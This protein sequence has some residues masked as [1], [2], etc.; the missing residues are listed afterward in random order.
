MDLPRPLDGVRVLDFTWVRAGPWSTRWLAAL[1]AEVLKVQWPY[2]LGPGQRIRPGELPRDPNA[3]ANSD[4]NNTNKLGITLNVRSEKGLSITKQLIAKSDVVIENFSATV[5]KRW[6]LAYEDMTAVNPKI[7][8]M[9]MAG[10]GHT[11]PYL[12]YTTFG[13]AAAAVAGLSL[14][15]GLPGKPPAGWGYSYLDDTGGMYG[16]MFVI[17]ALE[18]RNR[19]GEGQ[20]VDMGQMIMG[21]TLTGP[22]FLDYTVNGR[23]TDREGYPAGNRAIWPGTPPISGFRGRAAVPHNSYRTKPGDYNDWCVLGCFTDAEWEG[24]VKV[25][26]T[27]EWAVNAKYSTLL[28]RIRNQEELDQ[29][30]EEWT[31]TLDKYEIAQLCQAAGVPAAP[32]QSSEDRVDRDPQMKARGHFSS[33]L[34]HPVLGPKRHQSAPFTMSDAYVGV[35]RASPMLGQDTVE[36][37][38]RVL[39]MTKEEVK[40]G[41]KDG[42]FWPEDLGYYPQMEEAMNELS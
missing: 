16:A 22:A 8:Y 15:S 29:K 41:Y 32:V 4:E 40:E 2:S 31:L 20:H 7:I 25:M 36:V 28:G 19:T 18:A 13:P 9:S 42:T 11:G 26:G 6:G 14:M 5:M 35:N 1:G 12:P 10:F 37:M 38:Q 34:D 33:V 39:G 21:A 17:T 24:L 27:P 3:V 23:S 30:I